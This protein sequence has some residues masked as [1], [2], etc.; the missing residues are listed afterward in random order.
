M[1]ITIFFRWSLVVVVAATL[2]ACN[3]FPDFGD[4]DEPRWRNLGT[5]PAVASTLL[6]QTP[7]V[8]RGDT[9]LVGTNDGVWHRRISGSGDWRQLGLDGVSIRVLRQH[10][11]RAATLFAAGVPIDDTQASPFYRSDDSGETWAPST[12]W[13]R[14]VAGEN[15]TE[16]FFDLVIAPD[17]TNRLYANLSGPSVAISTDGGDTWAL[18]NGETDVFIN[19]PCVLQILPAHPDKLYQGCEAPLDN[20]WLATYDIDPANP[21]DLNNFVFVAGG[22]D[23]ALDN[24]RPNSVAS[25][26]ARPD[27]L[28]AGLEGELIA[29]EGTHFE[30]VFKASLDSTDSDL[31]YVYIKG[32]WLDPDDGDHLVFGGGVN[33]LNT[34]L[35]LF[36]TTDHGEN[37][38]QV[39]PPENLEGGLNNPAIE[40]I[41]LVTGNDLA[42]LISEGDAGSPDNRSL[43][44]LVLN[45]DGVGTE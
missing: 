38:E 40:Q 27:T 25:G 43:R 8:V 36:E 20:A 35:S 34:A 9:V 2:V 23:Y 10:P 37:I 19:D 18:A 13:P 39:A 6:N 21:L 12:T 28:Y 45:P 4:K 29:L 31:P 33:G 11:T 42:I 30:P 14:N 32:I 3:R 24:R 44:V 26:P 17:D 16:P 5:V 7:M 22:P 41:E 15:A 1:A